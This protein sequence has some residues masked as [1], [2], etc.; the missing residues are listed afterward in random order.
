MSNSINDLITEY[1]RN[2]EFADAFEK[3]NRRL[4]FAVLLS[5]FRHANGLTQRQM[6]EKVRKPQSTIA[7]IENG[8]MNPSL[9]LMQEIAE[10]FNQKLDIRFV[11][12]S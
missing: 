6:A 8:N 10:A 5:E 12:K 9:Q 11:Q 7:R 3:E 4:D 2:K 1:S